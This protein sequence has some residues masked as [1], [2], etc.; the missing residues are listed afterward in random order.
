MFYIMSCNIDEF[1]DLLFFVVAM[2]YAN[3]MADKIFAWLEAIHLILA[4]IYIAQS[5]T[6]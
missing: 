5:S 1:M 2:Y 3:F 6:A 4:F